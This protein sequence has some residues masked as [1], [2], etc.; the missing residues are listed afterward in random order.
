MRNF[1]KS[2]YTSENAEIVGVIA[3][4]DIAIFTLII[5]FYFFFFRQQL[6]QRETQL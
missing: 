3:I 1:Q 6:I 4:N 5:Y 2:I